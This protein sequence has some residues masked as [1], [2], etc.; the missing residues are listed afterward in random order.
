[1]IN[2]YHSFVSLQVCRLL[3]L[4]TITDSAKAA[5]ANYKKSIGTFYCYHKIFGD[6]RY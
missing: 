5:L 6:D 2:C 1:M 4:K 3:L